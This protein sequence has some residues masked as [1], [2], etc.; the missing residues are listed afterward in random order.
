M[1]FFVCVKHFRVECLVRDVT[2]R[3][4]R[5]RL[6]AEMRRSHVTGRPRD[7]SSDDDDGDVSSSDVSGLPKFFYGRASDTR[8]EDRQ[9]QT[10]DVSTPRVSRD[11]PVTG[12]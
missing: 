7:V 4:R 6:P 8:T 5:P 2:P 12:T 1:F 10:D 3:S 11:V 9:L